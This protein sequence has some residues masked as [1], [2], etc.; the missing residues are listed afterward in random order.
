MLTENQAILTYVADQVPERSLIAPVSSDSRY[1]AHEWMNYCATSLHPLVRMVFRPA[2]YAGDDAAAQ[3]AV[4]QYGGTRL[5]DA[6]SFVD[7][8]LK[9]GPWALGENFSVVDAYLFIMYVWSRDQRMGAMPACANWRALASRVN[10]RAAVKKIV[11]IESN[12]RPELTLPEFQ[13]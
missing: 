3:Q 4:A 9:T 7:S 6:A 12:D 5:L 2:A 10:A 11:A 1:R 13:C 8:K